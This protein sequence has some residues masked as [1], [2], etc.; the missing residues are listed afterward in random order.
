M[1]SLMMLLALGE[2]QVTAPCGTRM[3]P[4]FVRPTTES[5]T[6]TDAGSVV[7]SY[8]DRLVTFPTMSEN[9]D[10][11]MCQL[12][13]TEAVKDRDSNNGAAK[14]FFTLAAIM[15]V[16]L[17]GTL[18]VLLGAKADVLAAW[19]RAEFKLPRWAKYLVVPTM[20]SMTALALGRLGSW[21]ST[22]GWSAGMYQALLISG[23]V[24]GLVVTSE[25]EKR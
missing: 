10:L 21:F 22:D 23:F 5:L 18:T 9:A 20:F 16:V 2:Q 12:A 19:R 13:L 17:M 14:A 11:A 3:N 25:T 8:G 6:V 1:V 7:Y 24:A 4:C 15:V